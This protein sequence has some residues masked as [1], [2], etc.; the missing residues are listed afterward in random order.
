MF[1]VDGDG[2]VTQVHA[3]ARSD[4]GTFFLSDNSG[5]DGFA[6]FFAEFDAGCGTTLKNFDAIVGVGIVGGSDVDGKIKAHLIKTVVN[7][8]RGQNSDRGVLEAER[9]ESGAQILQN[10]LG[11]FAGVTADEDTLVSAGIVGEARNDRA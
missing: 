8:R 2:F 9:F 3:V 4:F 10:P 11:G 1:A 5:F 6:A 7:G